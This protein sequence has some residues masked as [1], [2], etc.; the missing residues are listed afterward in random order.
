MVVKCMEDA[1]LWAE[2]FRRED[3][4]VV[5]I[6]KDLLSSSVHV[7]RHAKVV[8]DGASYG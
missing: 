3:R 2:C 5:S 1:N 7:T 8:D 6:W 4:V